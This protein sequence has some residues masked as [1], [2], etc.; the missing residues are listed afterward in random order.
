M[1][2]YGSGRR[3]R[4]TSVEDCLF[5][6]INKLRRA[7]FSP[8]PVFV[9]SARALGKKKVVSIASKLS[10]EQD[11][12]PLLGIGYHADTIVKM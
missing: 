2:G 4:K 6:D 8:A 10:D 7:G 1:G 9:K 11:D 3:Q 12:N 5:L